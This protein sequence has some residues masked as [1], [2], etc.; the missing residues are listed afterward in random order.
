MMLEA[1]EYIKR[2]KLAYY[3]R[4]ERRVE[5]M[6]STL[7]IPR[8]LPNR[9]AFL[10]GLSASALA[11]PAVAANSTLPNLTQGTIPELWY[12]TQGGGS[13]VDRKYN[14]SG[15]I[16][17]KDF[18]AVGDNSTDDWLAIQSAIN[19][20]GSDQRGIIGF[21]TGTYLISQPLILAMNTAYP[22]IKLIGLGAAK[23]TGGFAG[24][25]IDRNQNT[26]QGGAWSVEN[27][28]INNGT[29]STGGGI[30][31][32]AAT[33]FGVR[34]C[35][36]TAD[37]GILSG[38]SGNDINTLGFDISIDTC[39]FAPHNSA[40]CVFGIVAG[41]NSTVRDCDIT[42]FGGAGVAF[43]VFGQGTNIFGGRSEVN[44]RG[45][46]V[47]TYVNGTNQSAVG[48]TI[49]GHT[50]ESNSFGLHISSANGLFVGGNELNGFAGAGPGMTD[51]IYGV[52]IEAN[53]I[54][55]SL[56]S[57][58]RISV[59]APAA[60]A[61]SHDA[62]NGAD[63]FS[64]AVAIA[65]SNGATLTTGGSWQMPTNGTDMAYS[66]CNNGIGGEYPYMT[67]AQ[68]PGSSDVYTGRVFNITDATVAGKVLGDTIT[69]GG[70]AGKIAVKWNG[71][72][73]IW[74]GY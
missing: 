47:G 63:K 20:T 45:I 19:W 5:Q 26:Y 59:N 33:G 8:R 23:I 61:W 13:P 27:L 10:A 72:N 28:Y 66:N 48:T 74:S 52:R 69:V 24:Y 6:L 34:N 4:R 35:V 49:Q 38:F 65:A 11:L 32:G 9:R 15:I 56:I 29:N 57:S 7:V 68:L 70:A 54:L 18:G 17:V 41:M 46:V 37:N 53:A 71:S 67:F 1:R 16:N 21:P 40:T 51:P 42:G 30:R 60:W 55:S 2:D 22:I 36:I 58:T 43:Y 14:A 12:G 31:T 62:G 39:V 3:H 73:Y 44:A 25:I 64:R 50:W